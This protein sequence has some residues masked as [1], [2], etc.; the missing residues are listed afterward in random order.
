MPRLTQAGQQVNVFLTWLRESMI[1]TVEKPATIDFEKSLRELENL[2]ERMEKGEL[3]LEDSLKHFEQGVK[4]V[5]S[6]QSALLAADHK[7][8]KLI[9]RNG[10][11]EIVSF[12]TQDG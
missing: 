5:S 8:E 1:M 10:R 2:V 9:E 3:S 6:C 7:V 12:D 4:L 11:N